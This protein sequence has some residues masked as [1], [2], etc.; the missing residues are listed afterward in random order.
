MKF[1]CI[2]HAY[3]DSFSFF[4]SMN[5]PVA[6]SLD[7]L[8]GFAKLIGKKYTTIFIL[9][10]KGSINSEALE[11]EDNGNTRMLKVEYIEYFP[12]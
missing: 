7:I 9:L 12:F 10:C 3:S 4:A 8:R 2:Q 11:V 6:K 1:A 5:E